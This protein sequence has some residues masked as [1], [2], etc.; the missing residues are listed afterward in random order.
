V[1]VPACVAGTTAVE[2][3][4]APP[5]PGMQ[6]PPRRVGKQ[7]RDHVE[8]APKMKVKI[9]AGL[10]TRAAWWR[11]D[12]LGACLAVGC[13]DADCQAGCTLPYRP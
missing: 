13:G 10:K 3:V 4:K 12:R 6:K 11:L 9:P 1:A 7:F 5:I 8:A 2:A